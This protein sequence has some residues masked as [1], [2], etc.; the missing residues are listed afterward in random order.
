[1]TPLDIVAFELTCGARKFGT[2]VA[3][4]GLASSESLADAKL[5]NQV[6]SKPITAVHLL[7]RE[8][9]LAE[10]IRVPK[11]MQ[12]QQGIKD[13][14]GIRPPV[15]VE[16]Y[17]DRL[18]LA[19]FAHYQNGMKA[20]DKPPPSAPAV[21]EAMMM[22][23]DRADQRTS[24]IPKAE[25]KGVKLIEQIRKH[26]GPAIIAAVPHWPAVAIADILYHA[27]GTRGR[28]F[29][30]ALTGDVVD[31]LVLRAWS[32]LPSMALE[33]LQR[34]LEG[35]A[36]LHGIEH[37]QHASAQQFVDESGDRLCVLLSV[38][39]AVETSQVS[40]SLLSIAITMDKYTRLSGK[41]NEQLLKSA[42]RATTI[43][44]A[45]VLRR[46]QQY[47][48]VLDL[49]SAKLAAN[50]DTGARRTGYRTTADRQKE[51]S[52]RA[53]LSRDMRRCITVARTLAVY[54]CFDDALL[55]SLSDLWHSGCD[56]GIRPLAGVQELVFLDA[57]VR[58]TSTEHRLSILKAPV[59]NA[60]S[61]SD[62][63][64]INFVD[65]PFS[66]EVA[67][68]HP[69]L[70]DQDW[71]AASDALTRLKAASSAAVTAM[72][73]DVTA[74]GRAVNKDDIVPTIAFDHITAE[75][76]SLPIAWPERKTG[77]RL[78]SAVDQ[79]L[80]RSRPGVLLQA[81]Q[82]LAK[83]LGWSV[84]YVPTS[85]LPKVV[86]SPP[87]AAPVKQPSKHGGVKQVDSLP[88]KVAADAAAA[89]FARSVM[90]TMVDRALARQ[91][92][93]PFWAGRRRRDGPTVAAAA[94]T[95]GAISGTAISSPTARPAAS[96]D[97]GVAPQLRQPHPG[98]DSAAERTPASSPSNEERPKQP[99]EA[100]QTQQYPPGY[101]SKKL[102][103]LAHQHRPV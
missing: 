8:I 55:L 35:L 89:S 98:Q 92:K 63:A 2:V 103:A 14:Q 32:L 60:S 97:G 74:E 96:W 18:L 53:G 1:M 95:E 7:A 37:L 87:F 40:A 84:A 15:D 73:A 10:A 34:C 36:N 75:G 26:C 77:V 25:E 48:V 17:S 4:S 23:L 91:G 41:K 76:L 28:Q 68:K 59:V 43:L 46:V 38:E 39:N 88:S 19:C 72:S 90:E 49:A 33:D 69:L 45:A 12:G 29:P 31:A 66:A 3:S 54:N 100:P 78:Y 9:T 11:L 99:P 79:D 30:P 61:S 94:S 80:S 58:Y 64:K 50:G 13:D 24:K 101:W 81:E 22:L 85:S 82:R 42:A 83:R 71:P 6:S 27:C 67:W 47:P 20:G 62:S 21:F 86:Q 57:L 52:D 70:Q 44:A 56:R 5:L 65:G 16:D 93:Q 102:A 51:F